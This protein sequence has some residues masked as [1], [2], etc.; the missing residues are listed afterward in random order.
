MS[1]DDSSQNAENTQR[2]RRTFMRHGV[3]FHGTQF[4]VVHRGLWYGPFDYE[5]NKDFNG[6]ELLFRGEKF[7]EVCSEEELFLDPK[8]LRLPLRVV[9]VAT[10]VLG[11][12]VFGIVNGLSQEEKR[13]LLLN[14]L[15]QYGLEKFARNV[16]YLSLKR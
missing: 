13:E 9:H 14:N 12:V 10:V 1:T 15:K 8:P 7:G 16:V 6:V 2:P 11:T 3:C 4:W 5:W